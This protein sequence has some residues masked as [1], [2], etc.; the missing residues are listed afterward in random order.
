[1]SLVKMQ[2]RWTSI[3]RWSARLMLAA[4]FLSAGGFKL[5]GHPMMVDN[6]ARL[7]IG[8]W[9]RYFTGMVEVAGATGVLLP[10]LTPFTVLLLGCI[11]VGAIATHLFIFGSSAL[12]VLIALIAVMAVA[13]REQIATV[14]DQFGEEG[15]V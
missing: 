3:A 9:F 15:S 6:F 2:S 10:V 4:I 1:M 13:A 8:Q 14:L 12:P 7:G 5:L 11:M